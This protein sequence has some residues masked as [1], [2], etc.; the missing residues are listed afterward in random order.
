MK[1]TKFAR[2]SALMLSILLVL[3]ACILSSCGGSG[4]D[5]AEEPVNENEEL[6]T[7]DENE[8]TE[9]EIAGN[10][11]D[12][13]PDVLTVYLNTAS[14]NDEADG[15]SEE[16]AVASLSKAFELLEAS[17]SPE[18]ELILSG[19]VEIDVLPANTD[20]IKI[21][22]DGKEGTQIVCSENGITLAGP[23][24]FD[25]IN[26]HITKANK[27]I[28]TE[29]H[30][31]VLG[32]NVTHDAEQNVR[33]SLDLHIG[34]YDSD[35]PREKFTFATDV[36]TV[37]VGC[38]YNVQMNET[39]G[40][41]IYMNGG[42]AARILLG[43]D[44]WAGNHMGVVFTDDVN[45]VYNGGTIVRFVRHSDMKAPTFKAALQIIANNGLA[46]PEIPEVSAEGGK[47][48][49]SCEASEGSYL[50]PTEEAGTFKVYGEKTAVA[51]SEDAE[52]VS[53]GGYLVVPAGTYTVSFVDEEFY[54]NSGEK[55]EFTSDYT[56]SPKYL[57][58]TPFDNKLFLGWT[59]EDGT[60]LEDTA[61]F[62][63]GDVLVAVYADYTESDFAIL[64]PKAFVDAK[65]GT[66]LGVKL[67]T[68]L[69]DTVKGLDIKERG[70]AVVDLAKLGEMN[71]TYNLSSA[72]RLPNGEDAQDVVFTDCSGTQYAKNSYAAK[73]Y[74]VYTDLFGEDK[75]LYTNKV[76][77]Q[78]YELINDRA[79]EEL[80]NEEK[81]VIDTYI[82][83]VKKA[84]REKY[85]AEEKI[86]IVGSSDDKKGWIYQ[87]KDTRLMVREVDIDTGS[88]KEPI[89]IIQVSDLHFNYLNDR[90]FEEANP[91]ILATYNGRKWNAN[92]SSVPNAVRSLD[93]ASTA[94]QIVVTGDVLDYMSWGAIE[95]MW[96]HIFTPY[97]DAIVTLGNHEATRRCQDNPATP[98][99]TTLE[100]RME[101]LQENWAHDIY[102]YSK[103]LDER[104]MIIQM[105]DGAASTFWDSQVEPLK[106][107]L[108][109]AKEKGYT[110]LLFF[111]I[112]LCTGNPE[113]TEVYAIRGNDGNVYD[114]Y[115]NYIGKEGT[116]GVNKEVYD[117]ITN[118]AD[119]IKGIFT[120]HKHGDYYTEILA[121]TSTGE[122]A[123]I[124]QYVLT[125]TPYDQGHALV[126]TVR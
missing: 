26:F 76:E 16:K 49:L 42:S 107:D 77:F 113:D 28:S 126:I 93:F 46:F 48:I 65:E 55:V 53:A 43:S 15:L 56:I 13:I 34:T 123:V 79:K 30:S 101:I 52:Y 61:E 60:K 86:D 98:D 17:Q 37:F 62:K 8:N 83:D 27:F 115:N 32:E 89:E 121:K 94:D 11:P 124:P 119:V 125:G 10:E 21:F 85:R 33:D 2:F 108:E 105:D 1:R 87:L 111:H 81:A 14:G 47:F 73:G 22:G 71:F 35:G 31:L 114:F 4:E 112:P 75:V 78:F 19:A 99:P 18:K 92:A 29:G 74:I 58:H 97:P 20:V 59:Y 106:A 96:K 118:N 6:P 88:G 70:I 40:A 100:S 12:E 103:V 91:S 109:L 72:V 84:M 7:T 122:D 117:I 64:D 80:S 50:E 116:D 120:G 63:G 90:D 3:G 36:G 41:D 66:E 104:V 95:L 57:Y 23:L 82:A 5:V 69:A 54:K 44:G 9:D 110:V 24:E 102:Y 38:Y 51:K 39:A 25:N 68:K 67:E 45:I